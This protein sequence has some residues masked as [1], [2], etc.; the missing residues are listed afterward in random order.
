M[1]YK[2]F[3][4]KKGMQNEVHWVTVLIDYFGG[5]GAGEEEEEDDER[6]SCCFSL[7]ILN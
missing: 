3:G 5:G 4:L 6:R 1:V 2:Q 7:N